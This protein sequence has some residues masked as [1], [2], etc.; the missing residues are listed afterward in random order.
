MAWVSFLTGSIVP[1]LAVVIPLWGCARVGVF[2]R[3]KVVLQDTL[4]HRHEA[5][6]VEGF[7][8]KSIIV[9]KRD[10]PAMLMFERASPAEDPNTWTAFVQTYSISSFRP[11]EFGIVRL[12]N[13]WKYHQDLVTAM[14]PYDAGDR[15]SCEDAMRGVQKKYR[16]MF[17]GFSL[18]D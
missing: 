12:P 1:G 10:Y 3:E 9:V 14:K 2:G 18:D 7:F 4:R 5:F 15:K 17:P 6:Y 8:R 11:I 13:E 16:T